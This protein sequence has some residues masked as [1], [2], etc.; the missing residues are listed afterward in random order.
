MTSPRDS[1]YTNETTVDVRFGPRLQGWTWAQQHELCQ[2]PP[3]LGWLTC[4][5]AILP[6]TPTEEVRMIKVLA[7]GAQ[8]GQIGPAT[9]AAIAAVQESFGLPVTGHLDVATARSITGPRL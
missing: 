8:D 7:R 5:A 4:M 2:Q 6:M 9:R 3:I 1:G